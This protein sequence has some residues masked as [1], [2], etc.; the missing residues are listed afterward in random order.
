MAH[1]F[2][3]EGA[4]TFCAVRAPKGDYRAGFDGMFGEARKSREGVEAEKIRALAEDANGLNV[5]VGNSGEGGSACRIEPVKEVAVCITGNQVAFAQ[6]DEFTFPLLCGRVLRR[7][8]ARC[9]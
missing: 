7:A 2:V 3:Q 9:G 4:R 5:G 8:I 6:Q 1:F